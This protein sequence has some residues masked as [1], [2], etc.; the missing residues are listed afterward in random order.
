MNNETSS[1]TSTQITL[2]IFSIVAVCVYA[3]FIKAYEVNNWRGF[4]FSV[5]HVVLVGT[6]AWLALRKVR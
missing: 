1:R 3:L 4:W 6:G 5:V 2:I